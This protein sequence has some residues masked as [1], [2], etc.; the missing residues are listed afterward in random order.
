MQ[1][2]QEQFGR[3]VDMEQMLTVKFIDGNVKAQDAEGNF[4]HS[5]YSAGI[6]DGLKQPGYTERWKAAVARDAGSVLEVR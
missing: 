1:T 6:P 3:W 2:A 5:K 4:L